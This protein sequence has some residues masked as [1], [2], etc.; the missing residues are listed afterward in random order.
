MEVI[1]L[2]EEESQYE[3]KRYNNP[4]MYRVEYTYDD[5]MEDDLYLVT[6]LDDG[7]KLI[8]YVGEYSDAMPILEQ[9]ARDHISP[10][11]EEQDVITDLE[12][13]KRIYETDEHQTVP[14]VVNV[15]QKVPTVTEEFALK[16]LAIA[17]GNVNPLNL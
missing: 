14:V 15:D 13:P 7:T 12:P 4:G 11:T 8:N 17:K 10:K 9:W 1:K 3:Q 16:M 6:I 2:K 5:T